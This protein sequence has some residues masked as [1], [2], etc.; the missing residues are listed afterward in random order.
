MPLISTDAE[1]IHGKSRIKSIQLL[2]ESSRMNV[3]EYLCAFR[4]IRGLNSVLKGEA[5]PAAGALTRQ[6][7]CAAP[8]SSGA[9]ARGHKKAAY[10]CKRLS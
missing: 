2:G 8:T 10:G 4:E 3:T 6:I 1:A 7:G 5:T 9:L